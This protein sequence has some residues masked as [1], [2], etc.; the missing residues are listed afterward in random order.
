MGRGAGGSRCRRASPRLPAEA[1][2]PALLQ[3]LSEVHVPVLELLFV[4]AT[5]SDVLTRC[6][7]T[8]IDPPTFLQDLGI[9][10]L[11]IHLI[12]CFLIGKRVSFTVVHFVRHGR[13]VVRVVRE[14]RAAS[15]AGCAS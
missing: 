1:E 4:L 12:C 7:V 5:K 3:Q 14:L 8:V 9:N 6:W 13:E 15:C 11:S 2:V 10:L